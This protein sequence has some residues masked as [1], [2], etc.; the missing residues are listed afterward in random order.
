MQLA[1][2]DVYQQ[3]LSVNA[4][5]LADQIEPQKA[6]AFAA[7]LKVLN[8]FINTEIK[9]RALE[10]QMDISLGT[11]VISPALPA[12]EA[13]MDLSDA[14]EIAS[15]QM[16]VK[17]KRTRKPKMGFVGLSPQE[18]GAMSESFGEFADLMFWKDNGLPKLRPFGKC[19]VVFVN[20]GQTSHATTQYLIAHGLSERNM[21][22]VS[23]G[24]SA[25]K[26]AVKS[27]FEDLMEC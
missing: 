21:V 9:I 12:P 15:V 14:R 23:G 18:A 8:E 13:P 1:F 11:R 17:E 5:L 10:S 3:I 26:Y 4:S 25:M 20:L 2:R 22:K 27:R 16:D 6:M 24:A 19:D 7:N